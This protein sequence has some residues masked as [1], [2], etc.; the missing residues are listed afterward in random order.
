M[1][2]I[3]HATKEDRDFWFKLDNHLSTEVFEQKVRDGMAYLLIENERPIGLLRY[4]LF[5]DNT[6][7]CTM[8]SIETTYQSQGYGKKLMSFWENEM[9]DQ[10]YGMLMTSTQVDENAQHFYRNIGFREAGSLIIDIPKY[11]QPM[12]MFFIKEI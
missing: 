10:G 3:R 1:A 11:K 12:E 4:H 2:D 9:K 7:F 5:W 8:L 6:P